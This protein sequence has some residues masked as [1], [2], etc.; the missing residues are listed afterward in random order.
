MIYVQERLDPKAAALLE[1]FGLLQ[2]DVG[3]EKLSKCD[4]LMGWPPR[5]TPELLSKMQSLKVFQSL[6][7]GVERFPFSSLPRGVR[8]F[9]N[10]GGYSWPVAEQAWGLAVGMAK[11][12]NVRKQRV[13]PRPLRGRTLLVLGCGGIGSEV[14]RVAKASF[15]MK[16]IGLS[17]SF[18]EPSFFDERRPLSELRTVISRA[19]FIVD[20]LPST[21]ETRGILG[22][23]TL[24]LSKESVVIV[25]V[26]RGDTIAEEGI[27]RILKE[28][29][30]TRYG[31][32]VFW[33]SEGREAFDTPLWE[34]PN[35][36]GS[37][38]TGGYSGGDEG[39]VEAQVAAA[40]NVRR[41]LT[42]GVGRNLVR[43]EEYTKLC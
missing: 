30:E 26:G 21:E 24:K 41:I 15:S 5:V 20:T 31:T 43:V 9:S 28:R 19:D 10:A 42:T 12:V 36:G 33:R 17:R 38:H 37:L 34:L 40:E 22:Y 13:T 39:I 2:G 7:A 35:F 32:D 14:A 27:L 1:E 3:D 8:V 23:E 18:K 16:A 11:G 4:V 25:N 6:S 29:P